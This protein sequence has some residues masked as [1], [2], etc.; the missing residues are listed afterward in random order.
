MRLR[1]LSAG[2]T[3][4]AWGERQRL[5]HVAAENGVAAPVSRILQMS[6]EPLQ[7]TKGSNFGPQQ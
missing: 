5:A 7:P 6:L 1:L 3:C 4:I 2:R